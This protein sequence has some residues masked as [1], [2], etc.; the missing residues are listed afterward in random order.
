MSAVSAIRS[1]RTAVLPQH[2]L[3]KRAGSGD[4]VVSVQF[5]K[6]EKIHKGIKAD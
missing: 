4:V 6:H 1:G 5:L 2:D 3:E